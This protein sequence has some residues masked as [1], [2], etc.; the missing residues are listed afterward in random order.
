MKKRS[1]SI[2]R[3]HLREN[4]INFMFHS[5]FASTILLAV[6]VG[7]LTGFG[8]VGFVRLI[9]FLKILFF[10]GGKQVF[11]FLKEYYV[12]V[13]PALGALLV[14]PLVVWLAPEAKGHGVPE[15]MK[16]I[17]VQGG[18][19]RPIVVVVKAFASAI[20]IGSGASVGREGPIVQVGSALGS[21]VGQLFKQNETRIKNLIACGAAAGIAG[22]FNA[23]IAG[24]MFALEVILKDFGARAMSSVVIAAVSASVVSRMFLGDS[25]AFVTP[26]YTLWNSALFHSWNRLWISGARICFCLVSIRRYF[27]SVEV[28]GMAQARCWRSSFRSSCILFST[29]ARNRFSNH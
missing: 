24:V 7:V 25:P 19:I 28:S 16:A 15:V 11:S 12:I 14:G 29:G 2:T 1:T 13:I 23:P 18:R 21:S 20:A 27:R 5:R 8:V 3:Y 6:L 10:D 22:V 26:S 9:D 17:A 4:F